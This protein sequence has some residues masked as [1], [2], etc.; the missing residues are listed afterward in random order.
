MTHMNTKN[1]LFLASV[2]IAGLLLA[3]CGDKGGDGGR[4]A[5]VDGIP[6]TNEEF[7]AAAITK[8]SAE[9]SPGSLSTNERNAAAQRVNGGQAL[10][11]PTAGPIGLQILNELIR[12]KLIIK[13]AEE[14]GVAPTDK[15]VEAELGHRRDLDKSFMNDMSAR[16]HALGDIRRIVKLDL[17]RSNLLTKGIEVSDDELATYIK[18]NPGLTTEPAR[19]ELRMV[20]ASSAETRSKF[21]AE[22]A[23]GRD[24]E[25]VATEINDDPAL[26]AAGGRMDGGR[27]VPIASLGE[28]LRAAVEATSIN[29]ATDWIKIDTNSE[30]DA[31]VKIFILGK[32]KEKEIEMT[33]ARKKQIKR[34]IEESRGREGK[35]LDKKLL[36]MY[37]AAEIEVFEESLEKLWDAYEKNVV[38]PQRKKVGVQ[39]SADPAE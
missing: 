32:T 20:A 23:S 29:K 39:P 8:S 26:K 11:L 30:N 24:F 12:T 4:L 27:P 13:L 14:E 10:A 18:N 15:E 28:E 2:S 7:I 35:D 21:D 17:S 6:I 37:L 25:E 22:F 34:S 16:G 3:G 33:P 38:E 5:S 19:V 31:W 1:G 9:I 36:D